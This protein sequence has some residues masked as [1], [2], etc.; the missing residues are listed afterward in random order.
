[1]KQGKKAIVSKKYFSDNGRFAEIINQGLFQGKGVLDP[2]KLLE[3]DSTELAAFGVSSENVDVLWKERDILKKYEDGGTFFI[4][5]LE[6]QTEVH[7]CMPLR[8]LLYDTLNYEEQRRKIAKEHLKKKDLSGA[9]F[10]SGF[11]KTDVL[12]PV[13][14]LVLY[15]GEDEWDGARSLVELLNIPEEFAAYKDKLLDYKINLLDVKRIENLDDYSDELKALFGYIKYQ[16]DKYALT[17][18]VNE[19]EDIF[20]NLSLESVQAIAVLGNSKELGKFY[21]G[22]SNSGEERIDMCQALREMMED[23]KREGREEGR[24]EGIRALIEDNLEAGIEKAKLLAKL[25][26]RFRLSEEDAE[27]YYERFAMV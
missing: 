22:S 25:V 21:E 1:M 27:I 6:N 3:Q 18:F 9:E 17:R 24:E 14:T 8:N 5:G 4:I 20:R 10:L 12:N 19:N 13:F 26:L 15:Y 2:D 16:K 7:Y 11:A 23:A